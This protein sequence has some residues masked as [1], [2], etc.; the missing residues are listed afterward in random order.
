MAE[1]TPH[2]AP[3]HDARSLPIMMPPQKLIGRERTLAHIFSQLKM[4]KPVL[5]YGAAGI[6]K[7]AL[8]ASLAAAYTE[9]PPG[10]LWFDVHANTTL[11]E[12]IARIGRAYRDHDIANHE[13]PAVNLTAAAAL[14]TREKPL[15]VLDGPAHSAALLND[16]VERVAPQ[17][18]VLI[19]SDEDIPGPGWLS[20]RL[21]RLEP[22]QA[23]KLFKQYAHIKTD[24]QDAEIAALANTLNFIPFA[25]TVAAGTVRASQG[26]LSAAQF[27]RSLP[28]VQGAP[29]NPQLLA[30]TSAFRT[31][32]NALQGV[33]LVLGATQ[34][35][36]ATAELLS[37]IAST[38]VDVLTSVMHQLVERYL[39]ERDER[40]GEPFYR[41][42]PL[43]YTFA[44][45][46]L[47][48]SGRLE[49]LQRRVADSL[50]LYARKH[51]TSAS[52]DHDR[53]AAEMD[54]LIASAQAAA[55][56]GE[57]DFAAEVSS[58]LVSAGD[59]VNERGY[60]YEL[61]MLRRLGAQSTSAFPAHAEPFITPPP[62]LDRAETESDLEMEMV[63]ADEDIDEGVDEAD[64][65]ESD[66]L[67]IDLDDEELEEDSEEPIEPDS[68]SAEDLT[69]TAATGQPLDELTRLRTALFSA[70]QTSDRRKQAEI[71]MQIAV[72]QE[73]DEKDTEAISA[74]AEALTVY[75]AL[76][77]QP[78]M[79]AALDKLALLTARTENSQ[80]AILY[81]ARGA[82]IA[83]LLRD[84]LRQMRLLTILGDERQ[85]LGESEAAIRAYR[86]ALAIALRSADARNEALLRFKLGYALL[87]D[88]RPDEAAAEWEQ[89]LTLFRQQ[90]R[91]DYEGR[92]LGGLGT[93]Y[94]EMGRW[95]QAI[96]F[97]TSALQIAHEVADKEEEALQLSS[98]G[99]AHVQAHEAGI[100]LPN[101]PNQLG[102]AVLR[103]RQALHL[104]YESGS[105]ENIVSTT[106]DLVRLLVES[107]KHLGIAELLVDSALELDPHDRDLRK[108]K[109]RITADRARL[110]AA[111]AQKP[112]G[113][114]AREYAANAYSLLR[115]APGG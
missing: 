87:D 50:L 102:Q 25:L 11:N 95:A 100:T 34:T 101:I 55:A 54:N 88:G 47:R 114:S 8:A 64:E 67:P 107:P 74:Y 44:Q 40:Y 80:A 20:L 97:H 41:I 71:L 96:E 24:D 73:R 111:A 109:E 1:F 86:D 16:F 7:T 21:A 48:G 17:L 12:L 49:T 52:A 104:A 69:D 70:R 68:D 6:G 4:N 58:A 23:L 51:A 27:A 13:T 38:P 39:V 79:L 81:A 5:V 53:L 29:V 98:L 65:E 45:T 60:V 105:R 99:Y 92:V 63:G 18:P 36:A 89:A 110:G 22:D 3:A 113:G 59:F 42:H 78:G 84:S 2:E 77:D 9:L 32:P 66:Y 62:R 103:Y 108:W 14:L 43:I 106:V 83:E 19:V 72:I 56:A 46:W 76:N 35:G 75:E 30:L 90:H 57:R 61:L 91:R 28:Q 10:A 115:P 26:A 15:I 93:A 85:G 112:V 33:L 82:Q 31:L 94:G 37:M